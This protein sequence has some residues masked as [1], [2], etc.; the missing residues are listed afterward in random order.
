VQ[1]KYF[2]SE[3]F[4]SIAKKISYG[5]AVA[6]SSIMLSGLFTIVNITYVTSE[7]SRFFPDFN[8]QY[9]ILMDLLCVL[10]FISAC[11]LY[12]LFH[13]L[14]IPALIPAFRMVN[15]CFHVDGKLKIKDGLSG[16]TYLSILKSL[17]SIPSIFFRVALIDMTYIQVILIGY[18]IYN[19]YHLYSHLWMLFSYVWQ[20]VN[21]GGIGFVLA[22]TA[23]AGMRTQCKIKL[24]EMNIP[25]EIPT[26]SSIKYKMYI[27]TAIIAQ[28]L[29]VSNAFS[30]LAHAE[31]G[32]VLLYLFVYLSIIFVMSFLTIR[33]LY[34][35]LY[36]TGTV[37]E[38]LK[39]RGEGIIYASTT[40]REIVE[41]AAGINSASDMI[42]DYRLNLEEKVALRTKELSDAKSEVEKVNENLIRLNKELGRSNIRHEIDMQMAANVQSAFL[43]GIAPQSEDYD[44]ALMFLPMY[45]V[46]GDFYDFYRDK[47]AICGAG[48]FDVSGH[49]I[50][51]GLLTLLARSIIEKNFTDN[52]NEN[53]GALMDRINASLIKEIGQAGIYLTGILL[54]LGDSFVEYANGGHPE[55]IFKSSEEKYCRRVLSPEGSI[56]GPLMG[57]ASI[58]GNFKSIKLKLNKNDCL[59]AYTDGFSD[60]QD[61]NGIPYDE[62]RIIESFEVA[63]DRTA[64]EI[65]DFLIEDFYRYIKVKDR[66]RDDMTLVV[67]KKK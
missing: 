56:A 39:K 64:D 22:E 55:L 34:Q 48:L 57:I 5:V 40:D 65:L 26:R 11:I 50:S 28:A 60:T 20:I 30:F 47:E 51:S 31:L 46:S 63:P 24:R 19:N 10:P 62:K 52:Q 38:N 3:L 14:G 8:S 1:I 44:I 4:N 54:R 36:D 32:R 25:H 58:K 27:V 41:L 2:F 67:I 35:A 7:L 37:V 49:G 42:T 66:I 53:L 16:E 18:G 45:G 15:N 29:V 59:L 13:R 33:T 23:T 12:G 21:Y 43:P 61:S 6:L 17:N 9:I